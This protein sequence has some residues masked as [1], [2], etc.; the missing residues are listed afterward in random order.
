MSAPKITWSDSESPSTSQKMERDGLWRENAGRHLYMY[1][2][3][4][5]N[6]DFG[7]TGSQYFI[8]TCAVARRPFLV[9]DSLRSY[10]YDLWENGLD[11]EKF[12]ACEDANDVRKGVYNILA[13]SD[14]SYRVYSVYVK[15]S[16]VP[17]SMRTPDI[18]YAKVFELLIDAI[19]SKEHLAWVESA[20]VV[21]D[22][23]PKDAERRKVSRPLKKYMKQKFQNRHIPYSLL[24]HN[25][26]SDMN[27][28]V[29]DYF[30][31]AAQRDLTQNKHWPM[32]KV[33]NQFV[34]V[35]E[36]HFGN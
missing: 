26:A 25:S 29:A 11:I 13:A 14:N 6:L 22:K 8:M 4:S 33:A 21:T 17:V 30:C 28:Q 23:L 10:R 19:Y 7:Q 18:I 31:W 27:L 5:G 12:H 15:K 36:V 20:I 2:D 16:E 9:C 32:V 24:H 1:L 3:E 34:R 35:G